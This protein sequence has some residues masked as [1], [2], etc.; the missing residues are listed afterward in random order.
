MNNVVGAT[1]YEA[2]LDGSVQSYYEEK[3]REF[4]ANDFNRGSYRYVISP[5][6]NAPNPVNSNSWTTINLGPP[7][8]S[9]VLMNN[10]YL[11]TEV[12]VKGILSM[13]ILQDT[14][15]TSGLRSGYDQLIFFGWKSSIEAVVRYDIVCNNQSMF[16]QNF[17]GEE[18]FCN[19]QTLSDSVLE[20][21]PNIYTT[22]ENVMNLSPNVCGRYVLFKGQTWDKEDITVRPEIKRFSVRIPI[23]IPLNN[24]QLLKELRYLHSWMG[25]WEIRLFFGV[26]NMIIL[27][28]PPKN[29]HKLIKSYTAYH[30]PAYQDNT[31]LDSIDC[32][33]CDNTNPEIPIYTY[34]ERA[35]INPNVAKND[36][37]GIPEVHGWLRPEV[38][39][40]WN[41]RWQASDQFTQWGD[42]L[43]ICTKI[44]QDQ[45]DHD[46]T[47][48]FKDKY[49]AAVDGHIAATTYP[50]GSDWRAVPGDYWNKVTLSLEKMEM[51]Y[52][53]VV[54]AMGDLRSE[55]DESLRSR[56]L[57]GRPFTF[58]CTN[59][60][61]SRF[62]GLPT[63]GQLVRA[64]ERINF[65][66]VLCQNFL[67]VSYF[68][69]L[70][71]H[72]H[73]EHTVFKQP[74]I[75]NL[76][77]NLGEFGT[78]PA[79]N[80]DTTET[81]GNQMNYMFFHNMMMDTLNYNNQR[82]VAMPRHMSYLYYPYVWIVRHNGEYSDE[83]LGNFEK[84]GI[85]VYKGKYRAQD[86]S[87]W[88]FYLPFSNPFEFQ[89]GLSS[90]VNNIN[91][92]LSG[93]FAPPCDMIF[94]TPW[95]LAFVVE[96]EVMIRP[97]AVGENAQV[98]YSEKSVI[99]YSG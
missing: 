15:P 95:M 83:G 39:S 48:W 37:S 70:P 32:M 63:M 61:I 87:N 85:P 88:V 19:Y 89:G 75:S 98:L 18:S 71:A 14:T 46:I 64:G 13:P 59:T 23:K 50:G 76:F 81:T 36:W 57:G 33:E 1:T 26:Q 22:Y 51:Y 10:S 35:N 42:P 24:F 77:F 43:V 96:G 20:N 12:Y 97:D 58:Q 94:N 86:E 67:N 99:S 31:T 40:S 72:S 68:M 80:V 55:I 53:Q 90:P 91:I 78:Y 69:L 38:D 47:K 29:V 45:K 11:Q 16:S 7:G 92:K 62:T 8:H 73:N 30:F 84:H 41:C 17:V 60:V 6:Y 28:I 9:V 82:I 74:Y 79:E 65:T 2:Q 44:C 3:E 52:V 56:Y 66:M 27:P 21:S 93:T 34:K 25:K 4:T 5:S 54:K 49:K